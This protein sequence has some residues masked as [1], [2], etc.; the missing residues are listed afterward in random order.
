MVG[1]WFKE[2]NP[3]GRTA[4]VLAMRDIEC[5]RKAIQVKLEDAAGPSLGDAP[6]DEA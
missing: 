6:K 4:A 1:L 2:S 5:A 3:M